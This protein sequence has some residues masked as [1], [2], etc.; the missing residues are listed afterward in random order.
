M[1]DNNRQYEL[2]RSKRRTLS[3][4]VNPDLRVIVRAPLNLDEEKINK[5]IFEKKKWIEKKKEYYRKVFHLSKLKKARTGEE[6]LYLGNYY[7]L[8]LTEQPQDTFFSGS[9]FMLFEK[10]ILKAETI[11]SFWYKKEAENFFPARTYEIARKFNYR[12]NKITI[13]NAKQKWGSCD[14]LGCLKFNWRLIMAPLP[15]IDYVIVH[16]LT[17][18]K[19]RNHKKRFWKEVERIDPNFKKKRNW[20]KQNGHIL[21]CRFEKNCV[22][23]NYYF[24]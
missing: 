24:I 1:A 13:L 21:S 6:F 4:Q 16:E 5:F 14:S 20:L 7:P 17:H 10:K 18:L 11:F 3:L 9:Q 2:I 22:N 15:V 19:V 12:F 8:I 23:K